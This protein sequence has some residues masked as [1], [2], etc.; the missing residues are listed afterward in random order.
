MSTGIGI[1]LV[2][3]L[4]DITN[5]NFKYFLFKENFAKFDEII[6]DSLKRNHMHLLNKTVHYFDSPPGAFTLLYLLSE[7]H[8]SMHSWPEHGYLAVD[9]FTCGNCNTKNI[10]DDILNTLKPG[11]YNITS[12]KRGVGLK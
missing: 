10:I 12:L 3:D 6:E 7:S 5:E 1:H 8:L 11:K 9:I 4:F 2:V